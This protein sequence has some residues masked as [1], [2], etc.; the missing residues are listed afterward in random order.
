VVPN[1]HPAQVVLSA[2]NAVGV[3]EDTN[4]LGEMSGR[5]DELFT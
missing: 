2:M 4:T 1:A 3:A 5:I